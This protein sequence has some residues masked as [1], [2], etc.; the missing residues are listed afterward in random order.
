M[1]DVERIRVI[2]K[3]THK[4]QENL[5]RAVSNLIADMTVRGA[6]EKELEVAIE[7]SKVVIDAIKHELG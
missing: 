7:F 6:S 4:H 5:I 2:T 1:R 3:E